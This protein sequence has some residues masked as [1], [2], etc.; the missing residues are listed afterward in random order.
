MIGEERTI[1]QDPAFALRILVDIAIRALSPAVNDPTTAVQVLGAI[2]DL[3][4][5]I[6]E[7]DLRGRGEL[8]D[9]DGTLRV[10]VETRRWEDLLA[11]A[12]T[13]IREYGVTATQVTRR[14]RAL[15]DRLEARVR[16]EHRAAVAD[17]I[18][19]LESAWNGTSPIRRHA[20]SRSGRTRRASAGRAS[21]AREPDLTPAPR[22]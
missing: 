7:S 8:R 17:Q 4:L 1:E 13:E 9:G 12:L 18:A 11:L 16:P 10:L 6:G 2:E 21:A 22:L 5:L 19:A 20:R 15:L 14:T 3:L